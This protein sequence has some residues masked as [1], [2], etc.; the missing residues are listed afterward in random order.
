MLALR[1]KRFR[2]KPPT[3]IFLNSIGG[4]GVRLNHYLF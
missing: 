2:N 4:P 1:P 3:S